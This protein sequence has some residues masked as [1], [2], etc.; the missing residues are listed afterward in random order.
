MNEINNHFTQINEFSRYP[1]KFK[2]KPY[3]IIGKNIQENLQER[4]NIQEN[5]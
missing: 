4:Q 1:A 2:S 5:M 3:R